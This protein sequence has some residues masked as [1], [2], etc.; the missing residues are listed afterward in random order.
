MLYKPIVLLWLPAFAKARLLPLA[1][2]LTRVVAEGAA[3]VNKVYTPDSPEMVW[4][5]AKAHALQADGVVHQASRIS[6]SLT[7][8]RF[9]PGR[10]LAAPSLVC[11]V[12]PVTNAQRSAISCW[13]CIVAAIHHIPG[14]QAACPFFD[15]NCASSDSHSTGSGPFG[16]H[17]SG[18][19]TLSCGLPA[20]LSCQ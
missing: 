14:N 18:R 13:L 20:T 16:L 19:R 10:Q 9:H 1:I 7:I 11:F 6:S 5:F 8:L 4:A 3:A 17:A 15:S 12:W 2:Q